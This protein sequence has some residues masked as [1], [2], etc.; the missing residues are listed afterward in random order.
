M[1]IIMNSINQYLAKTREVQKKLKMSDHKVAVE[2]A[3]LEGKEPP[4]PPPVARLILSRI[5]LIRLRTL[6]VSTKVRFTEHGL[7]LTS[8][9]T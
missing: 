2:Q 7:E 8:S 9:L 3:K 6:V 5:S 4:P 1:D